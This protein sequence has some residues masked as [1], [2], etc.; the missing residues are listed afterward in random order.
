MTAEMAFDMAQ[1]IFSKIK[2]ALEELDEP[3]LPVSGTS[4][5]VHVVHPVL[6]LLK[7]NEQV[8]MMPS[9]CNASARYD[10]TAP[11][12]LDAA[13]TAHAGR[14][15]RSET[16][17]CSFYES[18]ASAADSEP[19]LAGTFFE[20]MQELVRFHGRT[21]LSTL[22]YMRVGDATPRVRLVIFTQLYR[23]G[24][25]HLELYKLYEM[26]GG[27]FRTAA[28]QVD[29]ADYP[30]WICDLDDLMFRTSDRACRHVAFQFHGP[31]MEGRYA[32]NPKVGIGKFGLSR[33]PP[34]DV[35]L[36]N[37][38]TTM[39]TN[40]LPEADRTCLYCTE[41]YLDV[42]HEATIPPCG[43]ASHVFCRSCMIRQ[44]EFN[45]PKTVSCPQCRRLFFTAPRELD[46]LVFGMIN[47]DYWNDPRYTKWESLQRSFADLDRSSNIGE[48]DGQHFMPN[49]TSALFNMWVTLISDDLADG[50]EHDHKRLDFTPEFR[51]LLLAVESG[52][53]LNYGVEYTGPVSTA[54]LRSH[55]HD[56]ILAAFIPDWRTNYVF[57]MTLEEKAH[58]D[59]AQLS[60]HQLFRPGMAE[61]IERSIERLARA[62][63]LRV[64]PCGA[65]G[66]DFGKHYHGDRYFWSLEDFVRREHVTNGLHLL[67]NEEGD[68]SVRFNVEMTLTEHAAGTDGIRRRLEALEAECRIALEE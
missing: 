36:N 47:G 57:P 64:C 9:A 1:N 63:K 40:Q 5:K 18:T 39:A 66:D 53:R 26:K 17:M 55:M 21:V 22:P 32:G 2:Q 42:G 65:P 11:L 68:H 25:R 15:N 33:H 6:V 41:S 60:E 31:H 43:V 10:P 45:D 16:S 20:D 14:D 51:R 61:A 37:V 46:Y 28:G 48:N 19:N 3:L 50:T 8:C 49:N 54:A 35:A 34:Y 23:P 24:A 52:C 13:V 29:G 27:E 7:E 62:L 67:P 12:V 4:H 59:F 56:S 58:L 38:A 44:C 30:Q